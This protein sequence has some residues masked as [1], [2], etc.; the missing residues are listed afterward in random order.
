VSLLGRS[1]PAPLHVDI[2]SG[3]L[4]R[5]HL[6]IEDQ[7]IAK[8]SRVAVIFSTGSGVQ[9]KNHIE[10]QIPHAAFFELSDG[11]LTAANDIATKLSDFSVVVGVGGGRVL[12]AAKYAAGKAGLPMIAVATNLAHDGIASPVA[13]L[14][15]DGTRSSNGVPVPAA[16]VIDLDIVRNGPD[17]FLRAGIGDVLSNLSAVA[18]WELARDTNG[19]EVDG[20]AASMARTAAT[21]LLNHPADT[22]DDDFLTALAEGLVLSGIAMAVAGNTRPCSGACHEISHAIDRLFPAKSAPHGEQVGVGALFAT[23]VRGDLDM[24]AQMKACLANHNLPISPAQIGLTNEEFAQ[25]VHFAPQT[26]PDRYTLLEHLEM[27]EE[28]SLNKVNE[29]IS[30]L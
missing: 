12:D 29:F 8:D 25:A 16:V 11:S 5:L 20:L 9:F 28:D 1:F 10:K 27:N 22:H 3:A 2:S 17:R 21:A 7:R 18:D 13:I 24:F 14:E 30:A 19:E 4:N 15:H 6:F 23:F 26:R